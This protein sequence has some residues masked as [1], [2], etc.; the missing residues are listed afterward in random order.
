M[1]DRLFREGGPHTIR[2]TGHD[3]YTMQI[4][5]PTDSLGLAARECPNSAC[6]PGAFK[7]KPGTGVTTGQQEAYCPYCRTAAEPNGFSTREQIRYAKEVA[8]N[9][10]AAGVERM[11]AKALG[12]GSNRKRTFDGGLI[13]IDMSM[14]QE[15]RPPARRPWEE[16]L[17]RDVTCPHCTLDHAVYGLAVWCPDCGMDIFLTHVDTESKV[18]RAMLNDVDRRSMEL[19]P[20]VATRDIENGLEDVVSIFE[21]AQKAMVRRRLLENGSPATDVDDIMA[22]K[23]RNRFQGYDGAVET[24]AQLFS[25]DLRPAIPNVAVERFKKTLEKRHPITHNL[26]IVDRKYLERVRSG[27]AE[28]RDV[29]LDEQE[30]IEALDT[31]LQLVS[32]VHRGLFP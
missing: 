10:A 22:K 18:L 27:E 19:G 15:R 25:F 21:A 5:L 32:Y 29:A 7:V 30:V 24:L 6:S 12:L 9:E 13:S 2:R 28:G 8:A 23:V 20:R 17:R 31:V 4:K 26:G 1:N 14:R 11:L 3:E 16:Q